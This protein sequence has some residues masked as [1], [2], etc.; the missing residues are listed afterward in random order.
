MT[1]FMD[2][3]DV[4][5]ADMHGSSSMTPISHADLHHTDDWDGGGHAQN[6]ADL[7]LPADRRDP[8]GVVHG[9]PSVDQ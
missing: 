9:D 3:H 2:S 8:P 4:H 6:W 5:Y 7:P 1:E